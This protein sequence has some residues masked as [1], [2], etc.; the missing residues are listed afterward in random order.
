MTT[1]INHGALW[2]DCLS[3]ISH[4][5]KKQSFATWLKHTNGISDGNGGIS[6]VV[7]N[8]FVAEWIDEHYSEL[9]EEA[10]A[11]SAG[12]KVTFDFKVSQTAID[13]TEINFH[14]G[15]DSLEPS[16]QQS[17]TNQFAATGPIARTATPV[18]VQP[19]MLNGRYT[20]DN[21]VVGNFNQFSFAAS[22]AVAEA[23]GQTKYNPLYI[24]GGVGLG[25]THILQAIGHYIIKADPRKKVIYATSEKF[26]SDFINSISSNKTSDFTNMYRSV[27]ALL[28]DDAQFFAGKE[29]TQ[30]QFFHTFNV[31]YNAGK[32]IVLSSDR[33]PRDIKGMEERLLSRFSWGLVTDIQAP[34]ME[35]RM[36][37]LQ[38]KVE[39]DNI[40]ISDEVIDYIAN[41]VTSNIRELEG[42]LIRLL[43]FSSLQGVELTLNVAQSVLSDT[44]RVSRKTVSIDLIKRKVSD[45]FGVD[46][47]LLSAK[48]K[49]QN[50]VQARQVAMY[51]ARSLTTMSLKAIGDSF[52]GRDH[53]TVIH[54][55]NLIERQITS[56][57][58]LRA[59]VEKLSRNLVG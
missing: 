21:L 14:S 40:S 17:Q 3:Y 23:P 8:Q 47:P 11:Q 37:I 39:A 29:S 28:I 38:R 9:I 58:T 51:L 26:T 7:P 4:R 44:L 15:H 10:L 48:K 52:G 33:A 49:T 2:Q 41:A 42:S 56:N 36:A 57:I 55:C 31:L 43:A 24:Y 30:E 27:D 22:K 6:I 16:A 50:I 13:Q 1:T 45:N 53:S 34:D 46:L 18:S 59:E 54:A 32:Q 12:E 5:L 25:K 35:T 20:Y 19:G